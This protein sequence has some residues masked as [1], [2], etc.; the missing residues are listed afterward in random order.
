[1]FVAAYQLSI[2]KLD[3]EQAKAEIQ[4]FGHSDKTLGDIREFIDAYN[5]QSQELSGEL[6]ELKPSGTAD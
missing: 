1:M 2:Q 6:K 4:S 3:K 5:P